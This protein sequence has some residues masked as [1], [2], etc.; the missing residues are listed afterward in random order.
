MK[1]TLYLASIFAGVMVLFST[2]CVSSK[3][4]K[5]IGRQV[6]VETPVVVVKPTVEAKN[7]VIRGSATVHSLFGIFTWGANVQAVGVDSG[8]SFSVKDGVKL[9]GK[10]FSFANKSE[11]DARSAAAYRATVS[12]K[13]DMILAPQYVIT[14]KDYVIYKSINCRVKGYPGYIKGVNVVDSPKINDGK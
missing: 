6:A 12:A 13:A 1:K 9:D 14:V 7:T 10:L 8:I 4:D 3:A 11:H 2:G 5:V